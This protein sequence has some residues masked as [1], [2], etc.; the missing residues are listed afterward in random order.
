M[1]RV[2]K[3]L[4]PAFEQERPLAEA[5]TAAE[6]ADVGA[7]TPPR[8]LVAEDNPINQLILRRMLEALDCE[9]ILV[10]N[11][12]EAVTEARREVDLILMDVSMPEM[13]GLNATRAIRRNEFEARRPHTPI[14]AL[15]AN[16][17]LE[18]AEACRLAGMDRF[19]TKPIRR[20][21]LASLLQEVAVSRDRE[22]AG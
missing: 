13:D 6:P 16:A 19:L 10:E 21:Q 20:D 22:L 5:S 1:E 17:L 8:V 3:P 7:P 15:T 12:R 18:D 14:F 2:M 4:R 9:V 11:G